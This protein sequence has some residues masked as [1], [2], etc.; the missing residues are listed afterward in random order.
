MHESTVR[1]AVAAPR[2]EAGTIARALLSRLA[3]PRV[4]LVAIAWLAV[5]VAWRFETDASATALL[6][7][8]CALTIANLLAA[9]ALRPVFRVHTALLVFHVCLVVIVAALFVGRMTYF[10]GQAEVAQGESFA[11]QLIDAQAGPWNDGG[12]RRLRFTNEGFEI[13]YA[14]GRRRADTRHRVR[15]SEGGEVR[16]AV[17]GDDTPLVLGGY[18]FYTTPN[19][20]FAPRL[21]WSPSRGE[22]SLG[23]VHLPP[24]PVYES[25]QAVQWQPPGLGRELTIELLIDETLIDPER[26]SRFRLPSRPR[27]RVIDGATQW[28][29]APGE[30]LSL[31]EGSLRFERLVTW[32]GYAIDHDPAAAWL[33]AASVIACLSIGWHTLAHWRA[34]PWNPA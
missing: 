12:V 13:D 10:R 11:G 16:E 30:S 33:L 24:Y 19:K 2:R 22:P 26:A 18:R 1:P 28:E 4:S 6:A 15:W 7:A 5:A 9:M 21:L 25:A 17:I 23:T 27:L 32:M 14:P 29:L 34:R 8:P 3:S 20:G 31:P